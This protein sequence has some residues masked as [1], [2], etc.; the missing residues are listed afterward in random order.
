MSIIK[1]LDP[2][3]SREFDKPPK[4]SYPQ[5]KI[6]FSLPH[7]AELELREMQTDLTRLGFILQ[8]GYFKASGRFFK[9]NTFQKGKKIPNYL[10]AVQ[11]A[12][13]SISTNT[14]YNRHG[15]YDSQ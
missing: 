6:M 2:T 8:L 12:L 11:I 15:V 4:F 3:Q 9:M 5:R 1:V 10:T 13:V 14:R 7:W